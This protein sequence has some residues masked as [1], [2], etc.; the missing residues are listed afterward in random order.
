MKRNIERTYSLSR[1]EVHEAVVAWLK[2]KNVPAPDYI[3]NTPT[4]QW[5]DENEGELK[6]NW[7]EQANEA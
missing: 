4:C 7:I 2:S 5:S 6:V 3:G 1:A